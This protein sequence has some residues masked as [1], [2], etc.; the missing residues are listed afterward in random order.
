MIGKGFYRFLLKTEA[1]VNWSV[2]SV[3]PFARWPFANDIDPVP[4]Y[5]LVARWAATEHV[6]E[7]PESG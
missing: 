3:A 7:A 6:N 5:T 2:E 4:C 1:E